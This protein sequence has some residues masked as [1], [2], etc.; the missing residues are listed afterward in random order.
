MHE[1]YIHYLHYGN[2]V[3]WMRLEKTEAG[4]RLIRKKVKDIFSYLYSDDFTFSKF[5]M[6][7]RGCFKRTPGGSRKIDQSNIQ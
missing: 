5:Q 4:K 1:K 3:F 7:G 2:Y 6:V